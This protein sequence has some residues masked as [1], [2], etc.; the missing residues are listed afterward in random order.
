VHSG[1]GVVTHDVR[2][3][4]S[5]VGGG[6]IVKTGGGIVVTSGGIEPDEGIVVTGRGGKTAGIVNVEFEDPS[7]IIGSL[8]VGDD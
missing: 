8:V 6:F 5:V 7:S 1:V 2:V 3:T 4:G